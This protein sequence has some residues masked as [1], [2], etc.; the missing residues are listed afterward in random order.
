MT[1]QQE[2]PSSNIF[3]SHSS[4]SG[5]SRVNT[6]IKYSALIQWDLFPR[7]TCSV[8]GLSW[9]NA[10]IRYFWTWAWKEDH[11]L[12]QKKNQNF[13][14]FFIYENVGWILFVLGPASLFWRHCYFLSTIIYFDDMWFYWKW[15]LL[16]SEVELLTP[17]LVLLMFLSSILIFDFSSKDQKYG[18]LVHW[19]QLYFYHHT[20][21]VRSKFISIKTFGMIVFKY[22]PF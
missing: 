11:K 19:F 8:F 20:L 5:C 15:G 12:F 14:K 21:F 9:Q 4:G 1:Q 16:Y 2:I 13:L 18:H 17:V 22:L 6:L 10:L 3:S 7:F